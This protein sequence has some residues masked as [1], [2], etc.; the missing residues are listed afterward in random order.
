MG[1]TWTDGELITATKLNNTGGGGGGLSQYTATPSGADV[2]LDCSYNDLVADITAGKVPYI[3]N[4][5]DNLTFGILLS[6]QTGADYIANFA[7][8]NGSPLPFFN[9]DPDL[10]LAYVD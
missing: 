10:P 1:Y 5:S 9:S 6:L 2:N 8:I 7:T 4:S 3:V